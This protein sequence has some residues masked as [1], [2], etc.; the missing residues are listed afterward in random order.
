MTLG[1]KDNPMTDLAAFW[2]NAAP[3]YAKSAIA[4]PAAYE[5]TLERTRSYLKPD[6]HVLELGC[7]TGSTPL[8]LA[9]HVKQI[10]AMDLSSGMLAIAQEKTDKAGIKNLQFVESGSVPSTGHYDVVMGYSLFH[11][12]PDMEA[13][14][15]QI[16]AL[17]PEGGY[18]ISKTACLADAGDSIGGRFKSLMIRVMIPLMQL[19]GKAPYVRRFTARELEA[20]VTKAGFEIV[21]S[22][23][24]PKGPPPAHYIVARKRK[25]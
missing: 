12:V 13:R 19:V 8:L 16:N 20:A 18:F 21:E 9:P 3:K 2:N 25:A 23:N 5:Y 10:T 24:H 1:K 4:D 11:L 22:G 17:L 14:F 7:G 15:K 6:D